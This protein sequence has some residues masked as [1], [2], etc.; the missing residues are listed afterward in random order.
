MTH[1]YRNTQIEI[2]FALLRSGGDFESA[3]Q[4]SSIPVEDL[5]RLWQARGNELMPKRNSA[6]RRSCC[7]ATSPSPLRGE[8]YT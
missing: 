2:A 3:A 5:V 4:L 8:L 6:E 7:A 1:F